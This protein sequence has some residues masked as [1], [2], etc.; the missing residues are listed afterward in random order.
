MLIGSFRPATLLLDVFPSGDIYA[1]M[2]VFVSAPASFSTCVKKYLVH[3][4]SICVLAML[5]LSLCA[6]FCAVFGYFGMG[7]C[8]SLVTLFCLFVF[9]NL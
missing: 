9:A 5:V 7:G 4:G 3:C 6:W 8:P 2:Y 1:L